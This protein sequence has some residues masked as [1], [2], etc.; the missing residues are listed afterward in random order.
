MQVTD[1]WII[2]RFIRRARP[3]EDE[4]VY[5]PWPGYTNDMTK[6]AALQAL[7]ECEKR[8][9]DIEFRAHRVR[10]HE[11]LADEAIQRARKAPGPRE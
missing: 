2:Q 8:W 10:L 6:E 3:G 9:P 5:E 7:E 1:V 4:D 11:K